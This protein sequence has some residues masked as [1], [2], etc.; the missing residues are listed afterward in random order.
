M[1]RTAFVLGAGLGTRLRPLTERLPKPLLPV[2]GLPMICRMLDNLAAA[3][4]RRF[5]INTH[6]RAE[7]YAEAFPGGAWRGIPVSFSHEPV[8]LDTGGGLKNIEPL[9][10]ADDRDLF[11][12]NG[13]ILAAPDFAR[14]AAAHAASGALATL[15]LRSRG[16]PRNAR[17]DPASGRLLDLRGRLGAAGGVP[18]L[19]AGIYC[20][21][22]A[23]LGEIPAGKAESVVEAFLRC[24]P[25]GAVRG[26]LDDSGEWSDLGTPEE[27]ARAAA[28][29]E[30]AQKSPLE[31]K[32]A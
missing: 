23:F 25:R 1:I 27:Y 20:A 10:G 26:L 30:T 22:R 15:L 19:F 5:I 31:A 13:D 18:C 29:C 6:H 32:G 8:L 11:V 9:L 2:G 3:G 21:S 16:E 17:F 14:L 12:C 24:I 4:V 7:A 28:R